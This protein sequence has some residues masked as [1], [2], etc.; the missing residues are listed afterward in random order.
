MVATLLLSLEAVVGTSPL[1]TGDDDITGFFPLKRSSFVVY[2]NKIR[3]ENACS[4]IEA[5]IFSSD[6]LRVISI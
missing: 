1:K 6:A 4:G 5:E 3:I 2:M